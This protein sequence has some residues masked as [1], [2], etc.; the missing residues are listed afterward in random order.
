SGDWSRFAAAA[1]AKLGVAHRALVWRGDKPATGLPAA[2]RAARHALLAAAARREG[3]AVI[4]RGHTADDLM[5]AELMRRAGSS[6]PSPRVWAPSP[7]WPEGRGVFLLRPLLGHRRA[8]LRELLT[9]LGERWI[10]DPANDD[11]RFARPLARRQLAGAAPPRP[12]DSAPA[13]PG[14]A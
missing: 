4:L 6:A 2:A 12:Q 11:P 10:E 5:E 7:A 3:A 9:G 8:D 14:L 13:W 1:A